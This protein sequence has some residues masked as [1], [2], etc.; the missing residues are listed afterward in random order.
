[1]IL[2]SSNSLHTSLPFRCKLFHISLIMMSYALWM[3]EQQR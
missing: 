2:Y 1:M 3:T